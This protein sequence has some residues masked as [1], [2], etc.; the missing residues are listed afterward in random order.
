[1]SAGL[2]P[3]LTPQLLVQFLNAKG[4]ILVALSST[5]AASSS[6]VSLLSELDIT[7]PADR[8]GLVVDHVNYDARSAAD[9]HDVLLLPVPAP[10][11]GAKDLFAP[12]STSSGSVQDQPLIAFP[13]GVG[14]VLGNSA[15][16][17]PVLSATR[18]AYSYNPKEQAAAVAG[19]VDSELFAAGSQ[20]KLV[21]AL[22]ARN[23]ARFALLGSAEMLSNAWFDAKVKLPADGAPTVATYNREFARRLA[24]WA[25]QETG[26]LRVNWIE[27]RLNEE[28]A[29]NE[30][31]PKIYRVKNDVVCLPF[32][33]PF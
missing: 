4:N 3:N 8:T 17:A 12:A 16:L 24:G 19:G 31:N 6:I 25:F 9:L 28:G 22:Q 29:A 23:S 26:V 5:T 13:R 2:G 30:T 32:S 15:L 27:H 21:S 10:K 11:L 20:L 1:M 18:T 33:V 14:H 7:L